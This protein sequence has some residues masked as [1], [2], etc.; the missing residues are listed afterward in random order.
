MFSCFQ[1]SDDVNVS[2]LSRKKKG[3]TNASTFPDQNL[4]AY[5]QI[6]S[7]PITVEVQ[8]EH[9]FMSLKEECQ[10][11][12]TALFSRSENIST[13]NLLLTHFGLG[14]DDQNAV[15]VSV[16]LCSTQVFHRGGVLGAFYIGSQEL[17]DNPKI[18]LQM[19]RKI[20]SAMSSQGL[21]LP[22]VFCNT[23][24]IY[25]NQS[26]HL[27][28]ET[29]E[30]L[31]KMIR[32]DSLDEAMKTSDSTLIAKREKAF[33][34]T[35]LLLTL[36][37]QEASTSEVQIILKSSKKP[38]L[39]HEWISYKAR[40]LCNGLSQGLYVVDF[41]ADCIIMYYCNNTTGGLI[42]ICKEVLTLEDEKNLLLDM[43]KNDFLNCVVFSRI[44]N[45]IKKQILIHAM[46]NN[47]KPIVCKL[48][49]TGRL[50]QQYYTGDAQL[51]CELIE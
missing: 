23:I 9:T 26:V 49:Q 15:I 10:L 43:L 5:H 13:L 20:L 12:Q 34:S 17:H 32:T 30:S 33:A 38:K 29:S 44:V 14:F 4:E 36:M 25:V 16:D 39:D 28:R 1:D 19:I 2:G 7:R 22:I 46:T 6:L 37:M 18:V 51:R 48:I 40:D 50:R 35:W 45:L 21:S 41:R 8:M 11:E 24:G 42:V 47:V 31:E 27:T 3:H